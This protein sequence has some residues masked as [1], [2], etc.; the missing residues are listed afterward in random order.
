M[1]IPD[2]PS[3]TTVSFE[4]AIEVSKEAIFR[5]CRIYAVDPIEPQDLFQEVVFQSWRSFPS[6][7][8]NSNLSTWIYRIALNVCMNAK[9]KLNQK[10][11]KT[12]H[13]DSVQFM[14][15]EDIDV[16]EEERYRALRSCISSL[17]EVDRSI[18]ILYLEEL[19]YRQISTITGLSENHVAV[20]MKRIRAKLFDCITQ[21]IES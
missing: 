12:T 16:S 19:S 14:H 11:E 1:P 4:E 3:T 13:L 7:K 20:K 2:T 9:H 15:S 21:K 18:I 8:G 10:N 17:K 5:I 6:F